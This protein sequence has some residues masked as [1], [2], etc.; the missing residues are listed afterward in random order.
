MLSCIQVLGYPRLASRWTMTS[1]DVDIEVVCGF[2]AP[3]SQPHVLMNIAQYY[4]AQTA[5]SL[6]ILQF[7]LT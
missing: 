2:L 6:I 5:Q 4:V 7:C 3:A 1:S